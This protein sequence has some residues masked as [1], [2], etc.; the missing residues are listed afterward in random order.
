M[1]FLSVMTWIIECFSHK[2]ISLTCFSL[3]RSDK[4]ILAK[5]TISYF[6]Y[7]SI[8]APGLIKTVLMNSLL[9]KVWRVFLLKTWEHFKIAKVLRHH[10]IK[11]FFCPCPCFLCPQDFGQNLTIAQ[12]SREKRLQNFLE[13]ESKEIR[14]E[15]KILNIIFQRLG[16]KFH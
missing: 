5:S 9:R 4:K 1:V 16:K 2:N 7:Q 14:G 11:L 3:T 6:S 13:L 8:L 12:K 15:E 10:K